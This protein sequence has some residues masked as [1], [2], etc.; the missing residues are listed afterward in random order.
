M[1]SKARKR[2]LIFGGIAAAGVAFYVYRKRKAAAAASSATVPYQPL[3]AS[4]GGT[5]PYAPYGALALPGNAGSSTTPTP[6]S[7]GEY[8]PPDTVTPPDI[9]HGIFVPPPPSHYPGG[10]GGHDTIGNVPGAGHGR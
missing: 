1:K 3:Y 10:E 4:T 2:A 7:T 9:G 5:N 6:T 8:H